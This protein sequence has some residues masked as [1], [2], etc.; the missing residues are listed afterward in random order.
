MI[1]APFKPIRIFSDIVD[2]TEAQNEYH[3]LYSDLQSRGLIKGKDMDTDYYSTTDEEFAYRMERW[4]NFLFKHM[5][6]PLKKFMLEFSIPD[7]QF[8]EVWTQRTNKLQ[9]HHP[10]THGDVGWSFV[11][12]IDVDPTVHKA[13]VFYSPNPSEEDIFEPKIEKGKLMI[14]P[15]YLLHYQPPS[16]SDV[17]RY[18][19]SGNIE[20]IR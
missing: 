8:R 7:L 4:N 10:H 2:S 18:I 9:M 3:S 20:E 19:I 5:M 1:E 13:T 17:D 12:Y 16:N 14:W 15:S 6:N 11:W